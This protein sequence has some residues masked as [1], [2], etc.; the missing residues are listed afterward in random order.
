MRLNPD[1]SIHL[2]FV[3]GNKGKLEEVCGVFGDDL[4]KYVYNLEVDLEEIQGDEHEVISSKFKAAKH[5]LMKQRAL[6]KE[7]NVYVLVEDTSLYLNQYSKHFNFPGPF[8][9]FL[10]KANGGQGYIDMVRGHP[11]RSCTAQCLFGLLKIGED[12]PNQHEAL[13]FK[14]E[15][16][17]NITAQIGGQKVALIVL[18]WKPLSM[19]G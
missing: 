2:I 6:N 12:A 8:C 4:M 5:E 9:K 7:E 18:F 11:D 17:G 19:Y 3:S 10:V 14:G 15:C 1:L 16:K 13:F